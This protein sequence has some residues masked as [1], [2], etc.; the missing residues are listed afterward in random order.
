M[1]VQELIELLERTHDDERTDQVHV[2]IGGGPEAMEGPLT[3]VVWTAGQVILEADLD[4]S[5]PEGIAP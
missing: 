2:W 1:T 4:E 5:Y 3:D